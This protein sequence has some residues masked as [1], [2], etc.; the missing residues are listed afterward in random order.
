MTPDR[1]WRVPQVLHGQTVAILASGPS[2]TQADADICKR[3]WT[4]AVSDAWRVAPWADVVYS[5]DGRWWDHHR[6]EARGLKVGLAPAPAWP[7]THVL[8]QD[9]NS[10][11]SD[12][13][14]ALATGDGGER[15][16]SSSGYQA[17]NLAVLLGAS[18]ILLLGYDMHIVAG[19]HHF[20]GDHPREFGQADHYAQM[21]AA[22]PKLARVLDSRGIHVTNCTP[23]SALDCFQIKPLSVHPNI[24]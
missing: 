24:P 13:P 23:G 18:R 21:R 12:D 1:A 9:N 20:F 15:H 2:L 8:R 6:P 19:K 22:F 7:Q 17:I 16:F 10:V 3:H 11:L 4:I 14:E 5:C